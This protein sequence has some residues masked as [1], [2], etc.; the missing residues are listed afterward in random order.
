[1][2]IEMAHFKTAANAIE[3]SRKGSK[4]RDQPFNP[5]SS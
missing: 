3:L 2:S 5:G 4:T 1:M